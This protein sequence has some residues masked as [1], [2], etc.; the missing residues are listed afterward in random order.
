MLMKCVVIGIGNPYLQDDR[1]GLV[2]V[3]LLEQGN[4]PCQTENVYTVGF[5]VMEKIRGFERAIIVDACML[6][7]QPGTIV[8]V[9]V[10]DIFS[11]RTLINSHAM[12]LGTTLKTGFI[13]FPDEMPRDIKILLI[14]VREIK[15]YTQ[16]MS[17]EVE[18]AV[19]EVVLRITNLVAAMVVDA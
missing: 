18:A 14:E 15:E 4:L 2:V 7:N 3:E 10:D 17:P 8:E 19:T 1:A 12:T 16:Q 11:T 6:G 5:E 9:G 13:C